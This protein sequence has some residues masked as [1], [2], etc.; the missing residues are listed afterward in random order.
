MCGAGGCASIPITP[1]RGIGRP[2]GLGML[3]ATPATEVPGPRPYVDLEVGMGP[4]GGTLNMFYVPG[5]QVAFYQGWSQVPP[6]LGARLDAAAARLGAK[7]PTIKTVVV[8][9]RISRDPGA[10]APLLGSLEPTRQPLSPDAASVG[11]RF[12][13]THAT[14]WTSRG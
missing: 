3:L 13:T 8:G 5:A 9:E 10:Y 12:T 14:P 6:D 2:E 11:I 4:D 7:Q 1:G